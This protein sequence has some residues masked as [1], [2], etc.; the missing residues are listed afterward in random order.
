MAE[1]DNSWFQEDDSW[2]KPTSHVEMVGR[3]TG[4]FAQSSA[5]EN[6]DEDD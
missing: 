5:L 2:P 4:F 1:N 6:E 3:Q